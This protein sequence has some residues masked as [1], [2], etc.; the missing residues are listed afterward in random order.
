[1]H[2]ICSCLHFKQE[3]ILCRAF[4]KYVII[5]IHQNK[6]MDTGENLCRVN[7]ELREHS[8]WNKLLTPMWLTQKQF[9]CCQ[10]SCLWSQPNN[11]IL[12]PKKTPPYFGM[13]VLQLVCHSFRAVILIFK[14]ILLY[15]SVLYVT[16]SQCLVNSHCLPNRNL[17]SLILPSNLPLLSA[18][19]TV[20][21][22]MWM[23]YIVQLSSYR[24][25]Q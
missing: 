25:K 7:R 4:I 14:V 5:P 9:S 17:C 1:M 3:E 21:P 18:V 6:S 12:L 11:H 19:S 16:Y 23:H 8:N 24:M 10:Y 13:R 20:L 15:F 22:L 2:N